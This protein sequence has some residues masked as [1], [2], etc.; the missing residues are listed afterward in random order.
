[1]HLKYK[2]EAREVIFETY[3]TYIKRFYFTCN[4]TETTLNDI[5]TRIYTPL[6]NKIATGV[7]VNILMSKI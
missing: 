5:Y 4:V 7:T 3:A 2:E 6:K 1:V